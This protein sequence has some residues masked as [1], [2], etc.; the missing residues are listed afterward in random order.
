MSNQSNSQSIGDETMG[1]GDTLAT[2]GRQSFILPEGDYDF[3]VSKFERGH[4]PGSEKMCSGPKATLTLQVKT[5]SG[6]VNVRTDLI[7]NRRVEFR[8]SEFFR[9]IGLKKPGERLVMDW[10]KVEGKCGRA[11]FKPRT[12]IKNGETRQANN[13]ESF[14]DYGEKDFLPQNKREEISDDEM[15]S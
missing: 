15:F 11:H 9:S 4:F 5:E 2:D 6:T 8:L 1:W 12:Y 10:S 3:V 7:L 14:Y 13:V